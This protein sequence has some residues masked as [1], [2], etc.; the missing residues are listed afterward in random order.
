MN[1]NTIIILQFI[2]IFLVA[3]IASCYLASFFNQKSFYGDDLTE[4]LSFKELNFFEYIFSSKTR[5]RPI[6][7]L[8]IYFEYLICGRN[9]NAVYVYNIIMFAITATFFGYM[10]KSL[11]KSFFITII[12]TILFVISRFSWY[13]ITQ[14]I[15]QMENVSLIILFLIFIF[16][17]KYLQERKD[18]YF[19]ISLILYQIILLCHER[20]FVLIA[21]LILF[22][23]IKASDNSRKAFFSLCI[24]MVFTLYTF[25][26]TTVLH[27]NFAADT[28][29]NNNVSIEIKDLII[30]SFNSFLN[31]LGIPLSKDYLVGTTFDMMEIWDQNITLIVTILFSFTFILSIMFIIYDLQNKKLND[32]FDIS[33]FIILAMGALIASVSASHRIE[34]RFLFSSYSLLLLLT[35]IVFKKAKDKIKGLEIT[36]PKLSRKIRI[37]LTILSLF[38]FSVVAIFSS[39]MVKGSFP[40]YYIVQN[41]SLSNYYYDKFIDSND[42]LENKKFLIIIKNEDLFSY[43]IYDSLNI[44]LKQFDLN[45]QMIYYNDSIIKTLNNYSDDTIIYLIDGALDEFIVINPTDSSK[46]IENEWIIGKELNKI[47]YSTTGKIK[48]YYYV[49]IGFENM[50]YHIYINNNLVYDSNNLVGDTLMEFE[51]S[52]QELYKD[53]F[54]ISII[55]DETYVPA[56]HGGDDIRELN[57]FISLFNP[58]E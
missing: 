5:F 54:S 29:G 37:D 23:L 33:F 34:M 57:M 40:Y 56:N 8:F 51:Y 32:A 4:Y 55:C 46:V 3:L 9:T 48:L 52:S 24:L 22:Y 15:G 26:K 44:W 41:N 31:V 35:A 58:C 6:T 1:K 14:V 13:N 20:Y 30:N 11:S 42:D 10:I 25:F 38:L 49:P 36:I 39:M 45:Y 50:S 27:M 18:K 43:D 19:Y 28:G 2:F 16:L 21:P 12:T 7:N 53:Y 47:F 17:N